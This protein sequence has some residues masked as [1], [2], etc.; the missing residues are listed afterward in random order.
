MNP[1]PNVSTTQNTTP[2]LVAPGTQVSS[3][4]TYALDS[5]GNV[6]GLVGPSGVLA[7]IPFIP[8][9]GQAAIPVILPSSGTITNGVL[10]ALTALPTAYGGAWMYFPAGASLPSGAGLY[11][12]SS[13]TT[14]G[15][16][17]T[18]TFANASAAFTPYIPASPVLI[19]SGG[20]A[21]TQTTGAD[22]TLANITVAGGVMGANGALRTS[23]LCS[24]NNSAGSKFHR[25]AFSSSNIHSFTASTSVSFR[26]DLLVRNAGSQAVNIG[27][28]TISV[29]TSGVV[30]TNLSRLNI[31]TSQAQ[32][33][34]FT[35]QLAVATDYI[36]LE[37]FTVEVL[38]RA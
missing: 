4:A 30:G 1:G 23:K 13:V 14:T 2:L 8:N 33:Y 32:Q 15:G 21:Y 26:W 24:H 10:S 19:T 17:I 20:A 16:N 22:I 38:P 36:V 28:S 37:G 6:T 27:P 25:E 7:S 11:W 3:F 9:G 31:D 18:T 29:G 5:S 12:V 35:C 34:T